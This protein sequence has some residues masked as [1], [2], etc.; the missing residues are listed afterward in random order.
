MD[1]SG[2]TR[3]GGQPPVES[4]WSM[5]R[6]HSSTDRARK[7]RSDRNDLTERWSLVTRMIVHQPLLNQCQLVVPR[8]IEQQI[9]LSPSNTRFQFTRLIA[10]VGTRPAW[11]THNLDSQGQ[12]F[13]EI[14]TESPRALG[15]CASIP[16]FG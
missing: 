2:G 14:D 15:D 5:R 8:N 12:L 9:V 16:S 4:S 13:S 6:A 7:S 1:C 10:R 3:N 11:V